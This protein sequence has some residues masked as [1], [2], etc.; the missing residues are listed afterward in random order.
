MKVYVDN[1]ERYPDYYLTRKGDGMDVIDDTEYHNFY[2]MQP[3][4]KEV[5]VTEKEWLDYMD[6]CNRYE[7][8]QRKLEELY[9]R[10]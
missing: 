2:A 6:V 8:W 9:G 1:D 4:G 10:L 7:L 3:W 5:D